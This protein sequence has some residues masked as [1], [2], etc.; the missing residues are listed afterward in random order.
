M[1]LNRLGE[2]VT[3]IAARVN[4]EWRA[5]L[6]ESGVRI[7]AGDAAN[8]RLLKEA[9]IEAARAIIV[10]TDN[11]LA[12]VS[13]ML[14]SKRA[15]PAI[16][17]VLRL[18]NQQLAPQ[19]EAS[20]DTRRALSTSLLAA[21]A[22]A[23]AALNTA[24]MGTFSWRGV[25]H[26]LARFNVSES[27]PLAGLS[28]AEIRASTHLTMIGLRR[29]GTFEILP[30]DSYRIQKGDEWVAA[31]NVT[32]WEQFSRKNIRH[33]S[34]TGLAMPAAAR[35]RASVIQRQKIFTAGVRFV[36]SVFGLRKLSTP[37]KLLLGLITTIILVSTVIFH[38]ALNIPAI[39]ALYFVV[40]TITTVGYGDINLLTA[41]VPVK[42]YGVMLMLSGAA[43]IASFYTLLTNFIVKA[44]FAEFFSSAR[45]KAK[46]HI[47]I[48]GLGSLGYRLA[49][50]LR[51]LGEKIV[52]VEKNINAE[53]RAALPKQ[54]EVLPGDGSIAEVLRRAG[55][56]RA[57]SLVAVTGNDITNL[58]VGLLAKSLNHDL[59]TTLRLF[60]PELAAKV[61]SDM[62]MDVAM[63]AS[64][65]AAPAFVAN[66][67]VAHACHSALLEGWL[68]VFAD[69]S[70]ADFAADCETAGFTK[71]RRT[72]DSSLMVVAR[73]AR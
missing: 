50:E 14:D 62:G 21:P 73:P 60:D 39:D 37:S 16:A 22:F 29:G 46:N 17:I 49:N 5:E 27:L 6:E 7:I 18:F 35:A 33:F 24:V 36:T 34:Q 10:V 23:A 2:Q 64:A 44:R 11:D 68:V 40:T 61:Q 66:A 54:V 53:F 28:L 38:R 30:P 15:N 71:L 57:R 55:I 47:V 1:M 19:I 67:L 9:H 25:A 4:D 72:D 48:V 59:R 26:V 56:E 69:G 20:F 41:A 63:S 8:E 43:L 45:V 3:V 58:S 51:S 70:Q 12:N 42:L 31:A 32:S 13:I 65:L 52:V